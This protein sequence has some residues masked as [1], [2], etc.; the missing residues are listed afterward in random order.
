VTI[1]CA[2]TW[3]SRGRSCANLQASASNNTATVTFTVT[4]GTGTSNLRDA[5]DRFGD[6]T[7]QGLGTLAGGA[8][9]VT[10]A[11]AGPSAYPSPRGYPT[12]SVPR[13]RLALCE[14]TRRPNRFERAST[15][16]PS[17]QSIEPVP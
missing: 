14:Q 10:H 17:V 12:A 7:S 9:T 3:R 8:V 6:G 4:R 15:I 1:T 5:H 2:T 11:Y 13:H 16:G